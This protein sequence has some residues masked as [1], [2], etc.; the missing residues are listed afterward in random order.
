MPHLPLIAEA[1]VFGQDESLL[2]VIESLGE[3]LHNGGLIH[4]PLA[5]DPGAQGREVIAEALE[6]R[7]GE[8]AVLLR[9]IANRRPWPAA[10]DAAFTELAGGVGVA[11]DLQ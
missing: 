4:L 11:Q 10:D 1:L 2:D 6:D 8:R 5:F 3:F 7:L 9:A